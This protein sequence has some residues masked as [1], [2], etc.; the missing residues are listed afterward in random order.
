MC[1]VRKLSN[2]LRNVGL[3]GDLAST[4]EKVGNLYLFKL[5]TKIRQ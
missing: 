5:H 1:W 3:C 4:L 2:F